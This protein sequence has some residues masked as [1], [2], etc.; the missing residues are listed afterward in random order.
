M[1]SATLCFFAKSHRVVRAPIIQKVLKLLTSTRI[2]RVRGLWASLSKH[3]D[4]RS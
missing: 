4:E 1:P 3:G 2:G